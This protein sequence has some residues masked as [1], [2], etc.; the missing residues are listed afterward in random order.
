MPADDFDFPLLG[1]DEDRVTIP[2]VESLSDEDLALLNAMLPWACFVVDSRGRRFGKPTSLTKRNIPQV[3]PDRRIVALNERIPLKDLTVLEIGC[4]EGV[5]TA[6]L[7]QFAKHVK[8]CDSRIE[9]VVKTIVRCGMFQILPSVFVWDV[10]QQQPP[11]QD[12][13]CDLLHHVG[14]L[15]HLHDPVAHLK[16]ML[17]KV[18]RAVML[19]THYA[20]PEHTNAGYVVDGKRYRYKHFR[21][22]GRAE[23]FSGMY[24][25][26]K[27][28]LLEDVIGLLKEAGFSKVDVLE[29]RDERN[30]P[31]IL[32]LA[33]R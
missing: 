28:L 11:G 26:A 17:P 6:G 18:S 3:V 32:I 33:E 16:A 9:N 23:P 24:E 31:R 1:F 20:K 5:H 27:W 25:A 15:Y 12:I 8:A 14:V 7:A 13:G 10:E 21:E 29:D 2:V 30:G 19:D 4:F 22:G